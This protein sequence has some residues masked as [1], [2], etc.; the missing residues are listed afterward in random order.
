MNPALATPLHLLGA[1]TTTPYEFGANWH[2]DVA[3]LTA[4]PN[5]RYVIFVISQDYPDISTRNTG[6]RYQMKVTSDNIAHI[7]VNEPKWLGET[8]GLAPIPQAPR[9]DLGRQLLALRN[10][11]IR[12]GMPL[13]SIEEVNDYIADL[14][15][16]QQ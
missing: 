10:R 3:S 6:L 4:T 7:Y 1:P 16:E 9:T 13:M 5:R 2:E 14:R 11:A 12:N 8:A 15:H